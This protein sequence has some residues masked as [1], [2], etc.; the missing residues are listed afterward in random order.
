MSRH[1]QGS[2]GSRKGINR[3]AVMVQGNNLQFST[4]PKPWFADFD[5]LHAN[6]LSLTVSPGMVLDYVQN[7][8]LNSRVNAA[9]TDA[10]L[11]VLL[12]HVRAYK[13]RLALLKQ[14]T[15]DLRAKVTKITPEVSIDLMNHAE[16]FELFTHDWAK[17]VLFAQ[18]KV[19]DHFR[20]IGLTIPYVCPYSEGFSKATPNQMTA[21][22]LDDA[23][24]KPTIAELDGA[25]AKEGQ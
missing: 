15:E 7:P 20:A 8:E 24:R 16:K 17:V 18:D 21:A 14:E 9:A 19:L 2:F 4:D 13:G 5:S 11:K 22:E 23:A 10:D 3:P 6:A 12:E 1:K 25:I